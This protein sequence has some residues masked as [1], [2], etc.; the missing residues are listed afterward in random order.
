MQL[1]LSADTRRHAAVLGYGYRALRMYYI[2]HE[3]LRMHAHSVVRT[4]VYTNIKCGFRSADKKIPA[5]ARQIDRLKR[6]ER[7]R[8][9]IIIE[10]RVIID[11]SH[12][13]TGLIDSL[14]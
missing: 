11:Y 12:T 5:L 6:D 3:H 9:I 14:I 2:N 8:I 1:A 13:C 7:A 10:D 4:I